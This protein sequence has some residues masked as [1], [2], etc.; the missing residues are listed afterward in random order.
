MKGAEHKPECA[1]R[2]RTVVVRAIVEYVVS[3]PEDWTEELILF[4]RNDGSW[5]ASN[6]LNEIVQLIQNDDAHDRCACGYIRYE[7]V[8]EATKEDEEQF[9][10]KVEDIPS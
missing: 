2:S 5:C 7:F 8:R 1:V 3:V 4:Q 10:V 6:G 9:G